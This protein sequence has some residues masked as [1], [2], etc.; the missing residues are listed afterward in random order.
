MVSEIFRRAGDA[1]PIIA[2]GGIMSKQDAE[3]KFQA[4]A[5]LVQIYTGFIYEGPA[6]INQLLSKI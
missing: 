2:V 1:L 4:G 5:K 6:L 3:E